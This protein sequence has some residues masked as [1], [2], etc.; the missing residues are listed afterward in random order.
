MQATRA[1]FLG[2][3]KMANLR[4]GRTNA[5]FC[6]VLCTGTR[7]RP[8]KSRRWSLENAP[9]I[10]SLKNASVAY[11]FRGMNCHRLLIKF[12]S[13]WLECKSRRLGNRVPFSP[14]S[15]SWKSQKLN[16][17]SSQ[18]FSRLRAVNENSWWTLGSLHLYSVFTYTTICF[19]ETCLLYTSPS[20]RDA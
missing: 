5:Y 14:S 7:G 12:W 4:S 10:G 18:F 20:P 15:I 11:I 13:R 2:L 9:W 17:Q 16:T 8:E 1:R 3:L 6:K 19:T